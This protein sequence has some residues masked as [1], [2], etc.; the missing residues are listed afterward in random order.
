MQDD[1]LDRVTVRLLRDYACVIRGQ[2][3]DERKTIRDY[4]KMLENIKNKNI[5]AVLTNNLIY[6]QGNE[7]GLTDTAKQIN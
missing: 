2:L 6:L 5:H 4:E 1:D 3:K 7:E